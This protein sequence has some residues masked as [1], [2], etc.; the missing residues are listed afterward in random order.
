MKLNTILTAWGLLA[1]LTVGGVTP[2]LADGYRDRSSDQT[3]KN[4]MRNL[5]IGGAAVAAYGLFNHNSAATLLG[6]A[7]A[8]LAGSQYEKDRQ[9]QS[10]D[11]N[12]Y[13]RRDG[14]RWD[15]GSRG[16][17]NRDD[18]WNR[19]DRNQNNWNHDYDR[20]R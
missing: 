8:V 17:S 2:A 14:R 7:G 19:N 15:D 10:Q 1:T 3:N 5:A 20:N 6:A 13:Y 9:E 4:N 12:R 18:N 16:N 11:S